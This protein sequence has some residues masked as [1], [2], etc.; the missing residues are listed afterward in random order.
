M[1]FVQP[2]DL[3]N[4]SFHDSTFCREIRRVNRNRILLC[5]VVFVLIFYFDTM[6]TIYR[7]RLAYSE[8]QTVTGSDIAAIDDP[9][10]DLT[11]FGFSANYESSTVFDQDPALKRLMYAKNGSCHLTWTPSAFHELTQQ[12]GGKSDDV[13]CYTLAQLE[14]GT[15]IAVKRSALVQLDRLTGTLGYLPDDLCKELLSCSDI[16]SHALRPLI[17]D[18]TAEAFSSV[19]TSIAFSSILI[20]VWG[21]WLFFTIRRAVSLQRDPAYRRLFACLGSVEDNARQIDEELAGIDCYSAGRITVTEHWRLHRHLFKF[22]VE[23]RSCE[24]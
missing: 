14:D 9:L 13:V 16:D 4:W 24:D 3:E 22:L 5:L 7:A 6:S 15:F 12:P 19:G 1:P 23:P 2:S 17:F 18:A 20:A 11:S 10:T 8:P 21:V